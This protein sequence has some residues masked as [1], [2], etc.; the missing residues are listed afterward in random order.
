MLCVLL[1]TSLLAGGPVY[2]NAS[3]AFLQA[4]TFDQAETLARNGQYEEALD[5]FRRL[6]GA[7]PRDLRG[8]L[9]IGRLHGLMGHPELAEPVYR[10]VTLEDPASIEAAMGLGNSLVALGRFDEGIVVLQRA[11]K[12]DPRNPEILMALGTAHHLAGHTTRAVLYSEVAAQI[13]PSAQTRQTLEQA[14]S[15]HNHRVELSSFGEQYNTSVQET[16]S[17]DLRVNVRLQER[18][19]I[20]GRGQYQRKFR[21]SEERG[22]GGVQWRWR[23]ETTLS[24]HALFGPDNIVLPQVDAAGEIAHTYKGATWSAGYRFFDFANASV[25]VI[26]PAVTWLPSPRLSLGLEYHAAITKFD[27]LTEVTDNHSATVRVG[28]RLQPRL[29]VNVGVSRGIENL[30]TLS[31]DRIG[32]FQANTVSGGARFD[33]PSLTSIVGLYEHQWRRGNIDMHR[34]SLSLIQRF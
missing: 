13:A 9:W 8:R 7:N 27:A 30:D 15:A 26:S 28:Y 24:A 19:R 3:T 32:S 1:L 14:R 31:P 10:S 29:W 21:F 20:M 22:G 34:L 2:R 33:L 5:A 23:P 18:L 16:A 11:E 4:P 17:A 12:L 6:V 25:S